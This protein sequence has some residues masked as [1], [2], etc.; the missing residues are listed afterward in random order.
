[1]C[2]IPDSCFFVFPNIETDDIVFSEELLLH[3]GV[4]VIPGSSFGPMGQNHLRI[5][6]ATST[7]ILEEGLSRIIDHLNL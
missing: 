1:N 4:Q 7:E 5:N 6:C 2:N 3:K